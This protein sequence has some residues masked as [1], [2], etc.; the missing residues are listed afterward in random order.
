MI[1][2]KR[3]IPLTLEDEHSTPVIFR[4]SFESAWVDI[5]S[6]SYYDNHVVYIVIKYQC[7]TIKKYQLYKHDEIFK[8]L[9]VKPFQEACSEP[10]VCKHEKYIQEVFVN[11][12]YLS[13]DDL[14]KYLV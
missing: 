7:G 11:K 5:M 8:T 9:I 3:C 2:L 13:P 1:I 10:R 4:V 6:T 12:F 14:S